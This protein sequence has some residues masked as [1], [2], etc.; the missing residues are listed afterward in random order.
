MNGAFY[1]SPG[2]L[3]FLLSV[4]L[5]VFL[6]PGKG[7]T[8]DKGVIPISEVTTITVPG[9]YIVTQ[10]ISTPSGTLI[11]VDVSNVTIDLNGHVLSTTATTSG[12]YVIR[13]VDQT[14]IRLENGTVQGGFEAI[15]FSSADSDFA[16]ENLRI[17]GFSSAGISIS[18]NGPSSP[19]RIVA[20]N[21]IITC[22]T[23]GSRYGISATYIENGRFTDNQVS[24]C[25]GAGI[26]LWYPS[27][28]L[29][30]HNTVSANVHG[31]ELLG[32]SYLKII[33]NIASGDFHGIYMD[34]V[35]N[36]ELAGNIA[37]N[38]G[39]TG[40]Q[41]QNCNYNSI[42]SNTASGNN[43]N[44]IFLTNANYNSLLK[45]ETA[46]GAGVTGIYINGTQNIYKEN[47]TPGACAINSVPGT[48]DG[49]GNI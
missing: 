8:D 38:N 4:S 45:N 49:G 7:M 13:S 43:T 25:S 31:L 12:N 21:N 20:A 48:I 40:I 30:G 27:N 35:H 19:N 14:L 46:C 23:G 22:P 33:E 44:G 47:M 37:S 16:V 42:H 10:D 11:Q 9:K 36:S 32:G 41:I 15:S 39:S 34:Q 18:G 5:L 29:L 26:S 28:S 17:A 2:W 3:R 6:L 24:L 1:S